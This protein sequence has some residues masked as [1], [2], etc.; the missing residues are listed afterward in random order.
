MAITETMAQ[1]LDQ[2]ISVDGYCLHGME[3]VTGIDWRLRFQDFNDRNLK[4][5]LARNPERRAVFII[6]DLS[7][8]AREYGNTLISRH[9]NGFKDEADF[10]S[11]LNDL[12]SLANK[13]S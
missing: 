6:G 1:W 11:W 5:Y 3:N 7:E 9:L 12:K 2:N 8:K 4:N 10:Q 13:V